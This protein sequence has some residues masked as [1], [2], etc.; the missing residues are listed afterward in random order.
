LVRGSLADGVDVSDAPHAATLE[1]EGEDHKDVAIWQDA[2]EDYPVTLTIRLD[3][4]SQEPSV[5]GLGE[6]A[7]EYGAQGICGQSGNEN[8]IGG[9]VVR[10]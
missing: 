2:R 4:V 10:R 7:A 5:V 8:V 9:Y 3:F 6:Y 1:P